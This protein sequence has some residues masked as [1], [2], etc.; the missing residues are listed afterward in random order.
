M[1]FHAQKEHNYR[2]ATIHSKLEKFYVEILPIFS[3]SIEQMIT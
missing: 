2:R 1:H 3:G